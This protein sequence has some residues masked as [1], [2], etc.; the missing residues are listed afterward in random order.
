MLIR[1]A[2][3]Q[4][5]LRAVILS[6]VLPNCFANILL[7]GHSKEYIEHCFFDDQQLTEEQWL[8]FK[9]MAEEETPTRVE[10]MLVEVR[11]CMLED[12]PEMFNSSD[13]DDMS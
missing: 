1:I 12:H 8:M 3:V 4:S 2:N 7:L 5:V 11:E 9:G 6:Q 10:H 13:S